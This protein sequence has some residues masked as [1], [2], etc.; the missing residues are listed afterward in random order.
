LCETAFFFIPAMIKMRLIDEHT[1][2]RSA[3][4]RGRTR[5]AAF[6]FPPSPESSTLIFVRRKM[7]AKNMIAAVA[8]FA[9]AGSV[10]ASELTPWPELENFKSTKTRA[11]VIAELKQAQANG[12]YVAGGTETPELVPALAKT[13]R[14]GTPVASAPATAHGKTRA[15][16]YQELVQAQ[17]DGS[18]VAGGREFIEQSVQRPRATQYAGK[19][20]ALNGTVAN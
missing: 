16:V 9:A 19:G 3:T 6:A 15:E 20:Q 14:S 18:Y 8:V 4:H 11:E 13:T 12:T 17:A 2:Q 10:F 5:R 1:T 7:N